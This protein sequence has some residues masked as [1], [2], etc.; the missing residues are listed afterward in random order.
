LACHHEPGDSPY[1]V[2]YLVAAC[3]ALYLVSIHDD[4]VAFFGT[5]AV[6]V[7]ASLLFATIQLV[8]RP[9]RA[10]KDRS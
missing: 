1:L 5:F 6:P 8:A 3:V 4:F 10:I 7:A 2:S 9:L